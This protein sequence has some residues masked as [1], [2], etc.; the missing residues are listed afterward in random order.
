[1]FLDRQLRRLETAKRDWQARDALKRRLVQMEVLMA[2]TAVR[3]A[4]TEAA[5]GWA[6]AE[7]VLAWF[8]KH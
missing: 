6:L 3:R 1:M 4:L 5:L 8:R 2:R 7:R